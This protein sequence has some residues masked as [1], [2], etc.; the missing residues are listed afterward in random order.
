MTV[1]DRNRLAE[2]AVGDGA[3]H[4]F[5][6]DRAADKDKEGDWIGGVHWRYGGKTRRL[7]GRRYVIL[8]RQH[9]RDDTLAHELGHF[10]GLPH[11]DADGNLMTP[12]RSDGGVLD[13]AQRARLRRRV[14]AWKKGG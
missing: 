11:S 12:G 1:A 14:R 9:A 4:V 3:V 10:F 5:V 13:D 2:L 6:V 7:R 8:S